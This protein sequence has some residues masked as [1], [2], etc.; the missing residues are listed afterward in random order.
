VPQPGGFAF[1][2]QEMYAGHGQIE[3]RNAEV[4]FGA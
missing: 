1:L 4:T 2:G 3:L